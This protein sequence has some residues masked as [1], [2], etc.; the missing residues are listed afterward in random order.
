MAGQFAGYWKG[1]KATKL[2]LSLDGMLSMGYILCKKV[3]KQK[4]KKKKPFVL[5]RK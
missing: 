3:R 1:H 2:T 5:F 4:K